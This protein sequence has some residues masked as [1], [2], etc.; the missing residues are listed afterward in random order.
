MGLR[1]R[2]QNKVK[3]NIIQELMELI[4]LVLIN[5]RKQNKTKHKLQIIIKKSFRVK[6]RNKMNKK[7]KNQQKKITLYLLQNF[8]PFLLKNTPKTKTYIGLVVNESKRT[9][10]FVGQK[11]ISLSVYLNK[12]DRLEPVQCT[13]CIYMYK[14]ICIHVQVC[15]YIYEYMYMYMY[16]FVHMCTCMQVYLRW[17]IQHLPVKEGWLLLAGRSPLQL[18]PSLPNASRVCSGQCQAAG[19]KARVL[20]LIKTLGNNSPAL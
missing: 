2:V 5:L 7:N 12:L 9:I 13:V 11:I 8:F 15:I 1:L 4:F 19:T 10:V 17:D 6:K 16:I 20:Q 18:L 3:I 14:H